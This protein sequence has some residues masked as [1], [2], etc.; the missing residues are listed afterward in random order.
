MPLTVSYVT[1]HGESGAQLYGNSKQVMGTKL[2]SL[3]S[4]TKCFLQNY[5]ILLV[6]AKIIQDFIWSIRPILKVELLRKLHLKFGKAIQVTNNSFF[7]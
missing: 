3:D 6:I 5:V 4:S 7:F 1:P 2:C